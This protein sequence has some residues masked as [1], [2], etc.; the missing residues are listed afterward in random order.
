MTQRFANIYICILRGLN[1][2]QYRSFF[3]SF[4]GVS[5]IAT[6]LISPCIRLLIISNQWL[7]EI[8][9]RLVERML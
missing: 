3:D 6:A 8:H 7:P 4:N 9:R 1:R 5:I 2:A